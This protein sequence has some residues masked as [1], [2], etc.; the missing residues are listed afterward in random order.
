MNTT[1]TKAHKFH[2]VQ[3][4]YFAA[5]AAYEVAHEAFKAERDALGLIVT[6]DMTDEQCEAI[7]AQEEVVRAKHSVDRL[8][9]DKIKAERALI[10]WSID[11]AEKFAPA[12][13]ETFTVLRAKFAYSPKV[14]ERLVELGSKLAA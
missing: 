9:S 13:R 6:D 14:W 11:Q 12:E 2:P 10:H 8:Q 3:D 7:W 1:R 5:R 4:A